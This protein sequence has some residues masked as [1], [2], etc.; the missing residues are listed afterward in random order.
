MEAP[1]NKDFFFLFRTPLQG[2]PEESFDQ[3][4]RDGEG[5]KATVKDSGGAALYHVCLPGRG[6]YSSIAEAECPRP[7]TCHS[8]ATHVG[9]RRQP[10]KLVPA[11][12]PPASRHQPDEGIAFRRARHTG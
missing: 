9:K 2:R 8:S 4:T 3:E 5:G 7:R 11:K 6:A 1:T 12:A 10:G